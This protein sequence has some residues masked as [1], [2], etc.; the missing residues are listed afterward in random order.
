M[1]AEA[2]RTRDTVD[3]DLNARLL[4]RLE[5]M[6]TMRWI[7]AGVAMAAVAF[8]TGVLRLGLPAGA[9]FGTICAL[10]ATNMLYSWMRRRIDGERARR[11]EI[12][13]LVYAQV[14]TDLVIL[15]LLV[16]FSGGVTNYFVFYFAFHIVIA[17]ILVPSR[18]SYG[19]AALG[20]ILV[21]DIAVMEATGLIAHYP[22][23]R[24]FPN[25]PYRDFNFLLNFLIIF[26]GFLFISAYVASTLGKL[27]DRRENYLRELKEDLEWKNRAISETNDRLLDIDRT[28]TNFMRMASHE[29]RSP[30]NA[31][32]GILRMIV[33]GYVEDPAKVSELIAAA[34]HRGDEALEYTADLLRLAREKSKDLLAEPVNLGGELETILLRL[35]NTAAANDVK[36][37]RRGMPSELRMPLDRE[38]FQL[39]AENLASNAVKYSHPGGRVIVSLE[40]TRDAVALTVEDNGIGI[41]ADDVPLIFNEFHRSGNARLHTKWGTGLGMA[42]AQRAAENIGAEIKVESTEGMGTTVRVRI[43]K[44]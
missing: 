3:A 18:A 23:G 22:L 12:D 20:A 44:K 5:W 1:A 6:G 17:S 13:R 14:F 37:E 19:V 4:T 35:D 26:N 38:S 31:M 2:Q 8:T 30:L 43:G 27:I 29:I 15:S 16:H 25:P 9:L 32:M 10:G 21:T 11:A 7:A 34:Y 42:I 33:E 39:L 40:E 24:Y 28:K 41:P 36:I